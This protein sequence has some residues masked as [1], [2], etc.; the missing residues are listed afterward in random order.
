MLKTQ[1]SGPLKGVLRPPGD[2]SISHRAAII[3]ALA[4]GTTRIDNFLEGADCLSTLRCLQQ[5]GVQ[6]KGPDN[7]RV[8]VHGLGPGGLCEPSNVLDACNSGTTMRL[9]CGVLAGQPFFSV[10]TGDESLRRRP[11]AR[12][13]NPLSEMGACILARDGN[14]FP[15]LAISGRRLQGI[16]YRLPVA[17]AQVKSAILLA[18]LNAEGATEVIE[19]V[20]SRDHTERMLASFG[21]RISREGQAIRLH[22]GR[23]D[24]RD[25]VVP[26]D[27]SSAAF[28]MVAATVIPGS[29]VTLLDV[30]VNPTRDGIIQVLREMGGDIEILHLS[31]SGGEPSADIRIRSAP[32]K[33][34]TIAGSII[35]RLIDEIPVL[36]LAAVCAQGETVIRDAAELKVK[37]SNRLA[38]IAR[39]LGR[40]GAR[41]RETEDGL[42]ISGGY[43]LRGATCESHG[44]HRI[45]MMVA[46]AGLV[47]KGTTEVV[48][49][50]CVAVSYPGFAAALNMLTEE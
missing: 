47:A 41:V 46:I 45:A 34:V 36:A 10:L 12:V 25:V 30:G 29:D 18:G 44:D 42:I 22:P 9:L 48:D 17:S 7:G 6:I 49:G 35:P 5:L 39:E 31:D 19:P 15:P 43:P 28:F 1:Q 21:A 2:K 26:G 3:G 32:L 24:A 8:V 33:G 37:E 11:M 38:A 16:S 23:L 27:I 4:H 50:E 13:I 14:R 40:L 20:P